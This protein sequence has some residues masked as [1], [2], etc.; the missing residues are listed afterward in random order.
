MTMAM[1]SLA[2]KTALAYTD[3]Q[4]GVDVGKTVRSRRR[5]AFPASLSTFS[6]DW[7]AGKSSASLVHKCHLL[8]IF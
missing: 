8:M 5:L 3:L 4:G 1:P 2:R 7:A 6:S